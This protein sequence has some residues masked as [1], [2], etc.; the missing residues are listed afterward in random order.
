MSTTEE[1]GEIEETETLYLTVTQ[2]MRINMPLVEDYKNN[3]FDIDLD[4]G[5]NQEKRICEILEGGGKIE[6]KTERDTWRSTGN[7]V[8]EY[9]NGSKLSG[10]S[11]TEADYW[12][13][14]LTHRGDMVFSFIFPVDKLKKVVKKMVKDGSA[15]TMRGG[16]YG[17]SKMALVPIRK[18]VNHLFI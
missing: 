5:L 3:Q 8:I 1:D 6:V 2:E 11:I 4:F 17:K 10:I 14:N 18:L 7:I 12:I 9:K 15:R 13:H 16:D